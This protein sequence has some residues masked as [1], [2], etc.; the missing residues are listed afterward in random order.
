MFI[1]FKKE[2]SQ[3]EILVIS[4]GNIEEKNTEKIDEK[5]SLTL[6]SDKRNPE[7]NLD[8]YLE[9]LKIQNDFLQ[10]IEIKKLDFSDDA[11]KVYLQKN[12]IK[13]LPAIIFSHNNFE[14]FPDF[15]TWL[16]TIKDFLSEMKSGEYYLDIWANYNPFL[17]SDNGFEI[18]NENYL[19]ELKNIFLWEKEI[20]LLKYFSETCEFCQEIEKS[21]ILQNYKDLILEVKNEKIK[22]IFNLNKTPTFVFLNLKT[23]E[24][25]KIEWIEKEKIA[26]V[27]EEILWRM[28]QN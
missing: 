8:S 13:T 1:I 24:F 25:K 2:K 6:I 16:P 11:T 23:W 3:D 22:E 19:E 10:D 5:L 14:V 17:A 9:I 28:R 20:V 26:E 15:E 27:F 7:T 12:D 18:V 4:S 21:N